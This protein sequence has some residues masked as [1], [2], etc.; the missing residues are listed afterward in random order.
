MTRYLLDSQEFF[1]HSPAQIEGAAIRASIL[2]RQLE[3]AFEKIPGILDGSDVEVVNE[4]LAMAVT[5]EAYS[6]RLIPDA[7]S[8]DFEKA[9]VD[10]S[11]FVT[12]CGVMLEKMRDFKERF[13]S[14]EDFYS[15]YQ[16]EI[17][18]YGYASACQTTYLLSIGATPQEAISRAI[19]PT[20]G[21]YKKNAV[22]EEAAIRSFN[23]R[24]C[25]LYTDLLQSQFGNSCV[26]IEMLPLYDNAPAGVIGAA[27]IDA[28]LLDED[29]SLLLHHC[30]AGDG[31]LN[32]HDD[33]LD[34]PYW[35]NALT[36]F[37]MEY[38]EELTVSEFLGE[39]LGNKLYDCP[40]VRMRIFLEKI[41][42]VLDIENSVKRSLVLLPV[43][44]PVSEIDVSRAEDFMATDYAKLSLMLSGWEEAV[45]DANVRIVLSSGKL[46][47]QVSEPVNILDGKRF[48]GPEAL[49]TAIAGLNTDRMRAGSFSPSRT[50][51]GRGI[52]STE[53]PL[54]GP[55]AVS[56]CVSSA[57]R[58][59]LPITTR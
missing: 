20:Y 43:N 30:H 59:R 2:L 9:R 18:Q 39:N 28:F 36:V 34:S 27:P 19:Q 23:G 24:R 48:M 22:M 42:S 50:C 31:E 15:K 38:R 25:A 52:P 58:S 26:N 14:M 16:D 44:K 13:P 3:S 57:V 1:R 54:T 21:M 56:W 33:A 7:D 6:E 55:V 4:R 37:Q 10:L 47:P 17:R 45:R 8:W 49:L 46:I 40:E 32:L 35:E 53:S 12:Q 11:F 5:R 51:P 41:V 29:G